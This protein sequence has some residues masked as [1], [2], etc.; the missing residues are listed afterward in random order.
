MSERPHFRSACS[1]C[2]ILRP[3]FD[4]VSVTSKNKRG[5]IFTRMDLS[6]LK[7]FDDNRVLLLQLSIVNRLMCV[8]YVIFSSRVCFSIASWKRKAVSRAKSAS[9]LSET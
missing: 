8:D 9:G 5:G 7:L 2:W 3:L 1:G 6:T 4:D